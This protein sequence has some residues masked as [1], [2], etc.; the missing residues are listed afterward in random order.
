[1]PTRVTPQAIR[2]ARQLGRNMTGGERR[3][4]SEL[5]EFRRLYGIHVRKQASIGVYTVDF[6]IHEHRLVV[7]VDG[8][9]TAVGQARD[10]VRDAWLRSI[11]YR[12]LRLKTGELA[13]S[14]SGCI[15]EILAALDLM[16]DDASRNAEAHAPVTP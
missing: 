10:A 2:R 4:W 9:F 14:F 1:M 12:V 8:H 11:G 3:L 7:E 15:V 6:V 13:H 5:K 16:K